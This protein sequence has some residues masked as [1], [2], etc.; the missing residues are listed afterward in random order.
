MYNPAQAAM[1]ARGVVPPSPN[2]GAWKNSGNP[3]P[4][5]AV[6]KG[7]GGAILL[8]LGLL[9]LGGAILSM[10]REEGPAIRR[11]F[12]AIAGGLALVVFGGGLIAK[13]FG[14]GGDD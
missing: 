4:I 11:P 13:A 5:M 2:A 1:M 3:P 14:W 9:L 7:V 12:K 6:L 8:L 10:T